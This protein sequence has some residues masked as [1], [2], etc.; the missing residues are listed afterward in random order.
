MAAASDLNDRYLAGCR[1]DAMEAYGT[2]ETARTLFFWLMVVCLLLVQ[3]V[4]WVVD[5]GG[6][7]PVLQQHE[8]NLVVPIR[9][10]QLAGTVFTAEQGETSLETD[11]AKP[12]APA[13]APGE[14]LAAPADGPEDDFK[15]LRTAESLQTLARVSLKTCNYILIFSAVVYSLVILVGIKIALVGQLGGLSDSGKA[16][17]LSLVVMLLIVPWLQMMAVAPDLAGCDGGI[18]FGYTGTLFTYD[19][20]IEEYRQI[21]GDGSV[22]MFTLYYGRFVGLW[23]LTILLLLTAQWRSSR[24]SEKIRLRLAASQ[25]KPSATASKNGTEGLYPAAPIEQDLS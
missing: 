16:F 4:F 8:R 3:A 12:A 25:D 6:I 22:A 2:F 17:F 7:D 15:G 9:C 5:R 24:A 18:F 14:T 23:L 11:S 20:L 13:E 21:R 19:R 10:F 1:I